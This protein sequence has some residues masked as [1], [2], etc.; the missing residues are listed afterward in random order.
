MSDL[1]ERIYTPDQGRGR[2]FGIWQD[3]FAEALRSRELAWRLFVRDFSA[4]YKQSALGILW[5]LLIPLI[6]SAT[7]VFLNSTG[8]LNIGDVGVPYAVYAL[9]S[10]T[11][12]QIFSNGLIVCSNAIVAGG[13]MIV[14]IN[15]PK[16]TL[17][18]AAMGQVLFELFVRLGLVVVVMIATQTPFEWT[19]LLFPVALLPLL[20]FTVG[21]GFLLSLLNVI[22]RDVANV[23]TLAATFLMFLTPVVYP[24]PESGLL[25]TVMSLNPLS[26]L[27]TAPRDLLL[28]GYISDPASFL[29]SAALAVILFFA[30]WRVFHLVEY[31]MAEAV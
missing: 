16:E 26:G 13:N 27:I 14:K 2:P 5:A 11:L 23:V 21:L 28:R 8:V 30:A 3:M 6:G 9:L 17:V 24:P 1:E 20:L 18:V 10:L 29:W 25:A 7:F 22:F 19:I 12:W 15:F 4:R 31:K